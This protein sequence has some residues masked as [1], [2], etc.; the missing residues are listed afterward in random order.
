MKHEVFVLGVHGELIRRARRDEREA[1]GN[2]E[3]EKREDEK[4]HCTKRSMQFDQTL[5]LVR[6]SLARARLYH[7]I[8]SHK[9]K[10]ST[11][12]VMFTSDVAH[13][14]RFTRVINV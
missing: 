9:S 10:Y 6:E 12:S 8:N 11:Q 14:Q 1:R 5:S 7:Y 4:G 3:R 2:E 13:A